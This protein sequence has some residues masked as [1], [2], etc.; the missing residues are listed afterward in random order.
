MDTPDMVKIGTKFMKS[1]GGGGG[2]ARV[3]A[4]GV[5]NTQSHVFHIP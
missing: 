5:K 1:Y 4:G 3:G 2:G